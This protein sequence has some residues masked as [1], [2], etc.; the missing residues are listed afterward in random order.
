[1]SLINIFIIRLS[2]KFT[3]I[4]KNQLKK[5]NIGN[6]FQMTMSKQLISS[7]VMGVWYVFRLLFLLIIVLNQSAFH[8]RTKVT[9]MHVNL[10]LN[11]IVTKYHII[12]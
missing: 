11:L 2:P 8:D 9:Y 4:Y 12:F 7:D 10:G 3:R 5:L 6:P 1:M